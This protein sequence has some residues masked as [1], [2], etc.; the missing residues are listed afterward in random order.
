LAAEPE[1][2]EFEVPLLVEHDILRFEVAVD[3]VLTVE[4]LQGQQDFAGVNFGFALWE[5]HVAD[6][7]VAETAARAVV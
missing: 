7:V 1:V 2:N 3:D 5:G 6:E 4:V